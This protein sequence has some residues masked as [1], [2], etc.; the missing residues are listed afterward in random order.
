M[1]MELDDQRTN[2]KRTFEYLN[3]ELDS[4]SEDEGSP[5]NQP[6]KQL[7]PS[8]SPRQ[9]SSNHTGHNNTA[10]ASQ[11]TATRR[12]PAIR[13]TLRP[14]DAAKFRDPLKLQAEIARVHNIKPAEYKAIKRADLHATRLLIATDNAELHAKLSLPWPTNAFGGGARLVKQAEQPAEKPSTELII[15]V[16][17]DYDLDDHAD[18]LREQGVIKYERIINKNGQPTTLVK[19]YTESPEARLKLAKS[20]V[21]IGFVKLATDLQLKPVQCHRCQ[22]FGH[23]RAKCRK[24]V[25]CLVC[26]GNHNR[27]DKACTK[28]AHCVNCGGP[29]AACSRKC[30]AS[31]AESRRLQ[32]QTLAPPPK[33]APAPAVNAWTKQPTTKPAQS[34]N[35][36]TTA[37]P[38]PVVAP[39]PALTDNQALLAKRLDAMEASVKAHEELTLRQQELNERRS[40]ALQTQMEQLQGQ[41]N[42]QSDILGQH[43]AALGEH[44][45]QLNWLRAQFNEFADK[46]NKLHSLIASR[47]TKPNS[48]INTSNQNNASS[49]NNSSSRT[50]LIN[51]VASTAAK[52]SPTLQDATNK[53][54][55]T[56]AVKTTASKAQK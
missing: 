1:D 29:H 43:T 51:S 2:N 25:A 30:P 19:L 32:K 22:G 11:A 52:T 21:T 12:L 36:T 4:S 13:L 50:S 26:G 53:I 31:L 48:Q 10:S 34:T 46:Q 38:Q 40:A 41:L 45:I 39:P 5:T 42:Q 47:M 49:N 15:H 27:E 35:N 56:S 37:K 17:L 44:T 3:D 24:P 54:T 16:S 23:S 28:Q 7:C 6:T 8:G 55:A 14:V 18:Q 9:T 33:P 20:K